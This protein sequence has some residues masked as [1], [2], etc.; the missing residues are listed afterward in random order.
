[1]GG[2]FPGSAGVTIDYMTIATLGDA[3]D[4]GDLL[5]ARLGAHG[6]A[7]SGTRAVTAGGASPTQQIQMEFVQIMSTGNAQVFGDLLAAQQY[8][9]TISNGHGGLG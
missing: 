5:T 8:G 9:C 7:A 1:M 2:E 4:F 3:L 6:G